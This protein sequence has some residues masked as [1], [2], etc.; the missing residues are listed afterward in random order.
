MFCIETFLSQLE[1]AG[2]RDHAHSRIVLE[3]KSKPPRIL[4]ISRPRHAMASRKDH[5]E[6]LGPR[7]A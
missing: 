3:R 2:E 7:L 1:K 5:E 6:I 4:R